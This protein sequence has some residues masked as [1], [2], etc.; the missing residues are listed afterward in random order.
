MKISTLIKHLI[1]G[2]LAAVALSQT[3]NAATT[4]GGTKTIPVTALSFSTD[5]LS[6]A[7]FDPSMG[8]LTSVTFIV[9]GSAATLTTANNT[10]IIDGNYSLNIGANLF[11]TMGPTGTTVLNQNI[12]SS[13][14]N[15]VISPQTTE[16]VNLSGTAESVSSYNGT[17]ALSSGAGPL[18]AQIDIS[19]FIG[20][21][22]IDLFAQGSIYSANQIT[23]AN[24][25]NN[26]GSA[27]ASIMVVYT[28]DVVPEPSTWAMLVG[29]VGTLVAARRIKRRA[30]TV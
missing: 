22:T 25:T 4:I 20:T 17:G 1:A 2:V 8:T 19:K 23:G 16:F 21:G 3:A 26:D 30:T 12:A 9:S 10:D 24:Q 14:T 6:F 27:S 18:A 11:L 5:A 15:L 28:Y 29:G 7:Q 13:G